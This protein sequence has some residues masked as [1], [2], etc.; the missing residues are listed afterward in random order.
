M[1]KTTPL[2]M[3]KEA[4]QRWSMVRNLAKNIQ[5]FIVNKPSGDYSREYVDTLEAK[6]MKLISLITR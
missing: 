1:D 6:V 3:L 5:S 2:D 4:K